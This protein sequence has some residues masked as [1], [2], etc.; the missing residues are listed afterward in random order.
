MF[1]EHTAATHG[2]SPRLM[3]HLEKLHPKRRCLGK[4]SPLTA[5]RKPALPKPL[6]HLFPMNRIARASESLSIRL[7]LP[8]S[9]SAIQSAQKNGIVYLSI[10]FLIDRSGSMQGQPIEHVRRALS[11]FVHSLPLG[12]RFDIIGFGSSYESGLGGIRAYE[13]ESLAMADGY[14]AGI[15]ANF[16]GTELYAPLHRIL[17]EIRPD[18]LFLLT[19]GAISNTESVL[20]L[21]RVHKTPISTLGIGNAASVHLVRGLADLTNGTHEFVDDIRRIEESVIRSLQMALHPVLRDVQ[22]ESDCGRPLENITRIC[23]DSLTA[24]RYLSNSTHQNCQ[25]KLSGLTEGGENYSQVFGISEAHRMFSNILHAQTVVSASNRGIISEAET[26]ELAKRLNLLTRFTSLLLYDNTTTYESVDEQTISIGVPVASHAQ[27]NVPKVVSAYG[28]GSYYESGDLRYKITYGTGYGRGRPESIQLD[29]RHST[30]YVPQPEK[31]WAQTVAMDAIL[32][33]TGLQTANGSWEGLPA[34]LE[35]LNL[36]DVSGKWEASEMATALA[37]QTL[38]GQDG[39]YRLI[40][41]K[42]LTW[43]MQRCGVEET[44]RILR[45][46][47]EK[48]QDKPT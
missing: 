5:V 45:W 48:L 28:D 18:V 19:D 22:L 9:A 38:R 42:G 36:S 13:D 3:P 17:T 40:A 44:N 23:R 31:D 25:L 16:G 41:G 12:C 2:E 33:L 29:M 24:L 4:I 30:G 21:A 37:V 32:N 8:P 20:G 10:I 46:A 26:V 43:L 1:V 27:R 47:D 39:K 6:G 11:I 34:V 15:A 7:Q 35:L 14:I